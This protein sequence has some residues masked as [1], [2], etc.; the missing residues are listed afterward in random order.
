MKTSGP[1]SS[2]ALGINSV[3]LRIAFRA[4]LP[5]PWKTPTVT[6]GEKE[7][8]QTDF[9]SSKDRVAFKGILSITPMIDSDTRFAAVLT[10]L[11]IDFFK[12]VAAN[13]GNNVTDNNAH[14]T[15]PIT[16]RESR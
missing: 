12:V 16:V 11:A 6:C 3:Y 5:A 9:S 15:T 14:E 2:Q 10:V 4:L 7:E 13:D 8:E 1:A